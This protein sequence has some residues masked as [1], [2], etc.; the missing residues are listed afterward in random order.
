MNPLASEENAAFATCSDSS[1]LATEGVPAEPGVAVLAC[2][3]AASRGLP[4]GS[5]S[6]PSRTSAAP[7]S[8]LRSAGGSRL[9]AAYTLLSSPGVHAAVPSSMLTKP[10]SVFS[11]VTAL[12]LS[13]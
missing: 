7:V 11:A 9:S 12:S 5:V 1:R 4:A 10:K 6:V 13:G 8:T 3:N 2:R